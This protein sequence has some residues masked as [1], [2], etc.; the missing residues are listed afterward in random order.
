M[1]TLNSFFKSWWS[2]VLRSVHRQAVTKPAV[3]AF[4]YVSQPRCP[5]SRVADTLLTELEEWL[6]SHYQFRFN[7]LTEATE[8]RRNEAV[9]AAFSPV[10]NRRMNGFCID[11]RKAGINC[12]DRDINR[13]I[14]SCYIPVY[15]PFRDFMANLPL[16]DGT[17]RMAALAGRVSDWPLWVDGF[18][19]W[20]LGMVA[21][22]M[23]FDSQYGNSIAPVLVSRC[24]GLHKSTFCKMLLPACLQNYYTDSFDLAALSSAEQKLVFFGLIN[25]DELDKFTPRKMA[26]LKNVMQMAALNIRKAYKKSFSALPR[27]ASF[28]ATSNQKELLT[29]PTG[30]RRFFCME[31]DRQIDCTPPDYVQLYA[32]LRSELLSG[33]RYWF[34]PEEEAAIREHNRSFQKRLIEEDVFFRCFRPATPEEETCLFLTAAEIFQQLKKHNPAAML[35][36]SP[37]HFGRFL[38]TLGIEKVNKT[39]N[40]FYK[41]VAIDSPAMEDGSK[42]SK[43]SVG[44]DF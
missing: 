22:W 15:H 1:K 39:R 20:M 41:V 27:M 40:T 28:I 12:W 33:E 13:F 29:D 31:V 32:Q 9:D 5:K 25:L 42:N 2:R 24:Q 26:L 7:L 44:D 36:S 34:T 21:Q 3:N 43:L 16:W 4:A 17:D 14:H 23:E 18:H 10:D 8:F 37:V 11:A 30:S 19:R 35:Q 38:T 6:L